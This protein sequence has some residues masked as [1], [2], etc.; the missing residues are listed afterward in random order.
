LL[1]DGLASNLTRRRRN[2]DN[3]ADAGAGIS[4]KIEY[5]EKGS[6]DCPLIRLFGT[7]SSEFR[8]LHEAFLR[9]ASGAVKTCELQ[10]IAGLRA[11]SDC[12]HILEA[13]ARNEGVSQ[14]IANEFRWKLTREMWRIAAGLTEP[15]VSD[16]QADAFQWLGG[17]EARHGLDVGGIAVLTSHSADGRW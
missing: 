11:V 6:P 13:S 17:P 9:L 10:K 15:F 4:M 5:L 8:A 1:V 2:W 16:P 7:D 12:T 3:A 14:S